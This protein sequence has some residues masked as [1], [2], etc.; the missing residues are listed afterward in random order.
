MPSL[1]ETHAQADATPSSPTIVPVRRDLAGHT[2]EW[3]PDKGCHHDRGQAGVNG[4]LP[5]DRSAFSDP[6]SFAPILLVMVG[7]ILIVSGALTAMGKGPGALIQPHSRSRRAKQR[8]T[9]RRR[10]VAAVFIIAGLC[11]FALIFTS[12]FDPI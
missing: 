3:Q 9:R 5:C 12:F 7:G 11:A 8:A 1:P 6:S 4:A 2:A 10:W